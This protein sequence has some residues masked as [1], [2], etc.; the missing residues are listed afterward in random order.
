MKDALGIA[1]WAQDVRIPLQPSRAKG[2]L[3]KTP[4]I[5]HS[6]QQLLLPPGQEL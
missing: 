4:S 5:K 1:A 3:R 2:L 6:S